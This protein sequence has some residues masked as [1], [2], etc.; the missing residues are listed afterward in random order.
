MVFLYCNTFDLILHFSHRRNKRKHIFLIKKKLD[1][2]DFLRPDLSK[3]SIYYF[4]VNIS[5]YIFTCLF[6]GDTNLSEAGNTMNTDI[7]NC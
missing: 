2:R 6:T 5:T 3:L 1:T 7:F 4:S